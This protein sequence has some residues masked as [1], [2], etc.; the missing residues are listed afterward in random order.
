MPPLGKMLLQVLVN[1][2]RTEQA[3]AQTDG[4]AAKVAEIHAWFKGFQD[5]LRTIF[6]D[7]RLAC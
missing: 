2:Y 1:K 7:D 6:G 4:N 3:F 5:R